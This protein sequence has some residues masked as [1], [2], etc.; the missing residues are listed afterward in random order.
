VKRKYFLPAAALLILTALTSVIANAAFEIS[1][2][3]LVVPSLLHA[4]A[5]TVASIGYGEMQGDLDWI[6]SYSKL[7]E[8][9][10]KVDDHLKQCDREYYYSAMTCSTMATD[11]S[12]AYDCEYCGEG[13][14]EAWDGF[15]E[16]LEER[17]EWGG[18]PSDCDE[19]PSGPPL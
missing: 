10:N 6:I 5:W 8:D 9:G 17:K 12:V 11:Y 18:S 14:G 7:E 3:I 19:V 4:K 15:P 2:E 1:H 16:N 13:Y